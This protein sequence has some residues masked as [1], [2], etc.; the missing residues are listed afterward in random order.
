LPHCGQ[1]VQVPGSVNR[2][3][4]AERLDAPPVIPPSL[5][6]PVPVQPEPTV[7]CYD[8]GQIVPATVAV[9]RD[10]VIHRDTETFHATA[11]PWLSIFPSWKA[12]A[13]RTTDTVGRVDLC[14]ECDRLRSQSGGSGC[15]VGCLVFL[16]VLAT[17]A[18]ILFLVFPDEGRRLAE[19]VR[20]YL[21]QLNQ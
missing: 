20:Q 21:E 16:A 17:A 15:A 2:T 13:I 1:R 11:A 19:A 3:V 10:V 4:L 14:P 5:V 8:C 9:R 12:S 7:S 6:Q 18:G